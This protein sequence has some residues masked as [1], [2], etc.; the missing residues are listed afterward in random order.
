MLGTQQPGAWLGIVRRYIELWRTYLLGLA[1]TIGVDR[2]DDEYLSVDGFQNERLW[3]R[4]GKA[5]TA[6]G[7]DGG[8]ESDLHGVQ[9]S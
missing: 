8:K 2:L 5:E 1:A 3:R 9:C 7:D 4:K 6:E